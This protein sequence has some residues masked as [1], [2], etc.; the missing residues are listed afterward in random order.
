MI[1]H[2][3]SSLPDA[4]LE[5]EGFC[6][7]CGTRQPFPQGSTHPFTQCEECNH[8]SVLAG[9]VIQQVLGIFSSEDGDGMD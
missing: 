4:I 7:R 9:E 8:Y 6:L 3:L 1:R 2:P 5:G